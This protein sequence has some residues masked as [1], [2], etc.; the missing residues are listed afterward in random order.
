VLGEMPS[1]SSV[2]TT[3]TVIPAVGSPRVAHANLGGSEIA[4]D[5]IRGPLVDRG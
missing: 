3:L 2:T 1:M 4:D 5:P